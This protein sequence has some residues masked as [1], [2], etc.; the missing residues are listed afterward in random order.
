MSEYLKYFPGLSEANHRQTSAK[1]PTY[2]CIA[3][4][5]GDNERWWEPADP[6]LGYY[7]P[8]AATMGMQR[9]CLVEAYESLGYN[10]CA[11]GSVRK[12]YQKVAIY[13]DAAGAWTHA[14]RQLSD[15][16]WTSKLGVSEDIEH[17]APQGVEG[18]CYGTVFCF[19]E[20][21]D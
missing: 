17:D 7:W 20:K 10:T 8:D 12:G 14:A 15:G 19:M 2:N 21:G 16:K 9:K 3:W 11:D 1:T 5:A 6:S 13:A 18:D 4:A